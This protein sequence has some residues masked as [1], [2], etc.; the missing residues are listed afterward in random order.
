MD[1]KHIQPAAHIDSE[2]SS[3]KDHT[4]I[5]EDVAAKE[6]GGR[7]TAVTAAFTSEEE[8]RVISKLDWHIMPLISCCI[9]LVFWIDQIWGMHASREWRMILIL[10]GIGTSGCEYI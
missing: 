9:R 3:E 1:E 5:I 2:S 6:A 8:K 4:Q 10:V 7:S